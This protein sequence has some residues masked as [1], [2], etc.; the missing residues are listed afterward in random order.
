MLYYPLMKRVP[1]AISITLLL[2]CYANAQSRVDRGFV[3]EGKYIN[4]GFG[5]SFTY[6][7][8]WVVH[9]DAT[10]ERIMEL[11]K[12][13]ITESGALSRSSAE[14]AVKNTH[15]LLTVFRHPLGTPG[16]TFNPALLVIAEKVAHAPG[17]TNG[18][19]YLLNVRT[20]LLR[21][22]SQ[23]LLKEP[24]EY[25]VAGSQ[26]FRDDYAAEVNGVHMVQAYFAK[27]ANGYALAF[28]FL[29]EDQKSVD[30]LAKA[31]ESFT[32]SPPVRRGVTTILEPPKRKPD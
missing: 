4:P 16:I 32:L 23:A 3:H 6:P 24:V 17:I 11:G 10:N 27:V 31:M 1:L 28:I 22:G 30:E 2:C 25:R 12:E 15:H 7:K 26:F 8:D 29:G 9:G 20:L 19:D 14:V 18:K 21:A 13:K 5:F